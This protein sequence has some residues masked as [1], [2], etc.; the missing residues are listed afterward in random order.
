MTEECGCTLKIDEEVRRLVFPYSQKEYAAL[1]QRI[2]QEGCRQ[3]V[4]VWYGYIIRG[5]EQYEIC[6]SNG[7]KFVFIFICFGVCVVVF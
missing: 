7:I 1:E 6:N 2:L 5:F 3:P 4:V